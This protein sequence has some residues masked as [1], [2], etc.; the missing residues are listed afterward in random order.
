MIA[1]Q[2]PSDG[3]VERDC[4]DSGAFCMDMMVSAALTDS[5]RTYSATAN[6]DPRPRVDILQPVREVET[7][8]ATEVAVAATGMAAP[9]TSG[10]VHVQESAYGCRQVSLWPSTR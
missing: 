9:L 3:S 7:M 8:G 10:L 4:D 1:S 6:A 2:H 5:T